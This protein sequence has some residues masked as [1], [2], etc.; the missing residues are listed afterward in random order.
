MLVLLGWITLV[1]I[2]SALTSRGQCIALQL[3]NSPKFC[4]RDAPVKPE[5]IDSTSA[6]WCYHLPSLS[7]WPL[8][9]FLP[10]ISVSSLSCSTNSLFSTYFT[11]PFGEGHE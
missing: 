6:A 1:S 5:L 10:A 4:E 3:R 8:S 7:P 9:P 2:F 11:E